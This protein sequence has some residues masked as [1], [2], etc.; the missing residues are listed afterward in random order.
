MCNCSRPIS[1][2]DCQ[3]LLDCVLDPNKGFFIYHI[4]S[5][6]KQNRLEIASVPANKN[7]NTVA[8][9]RGFI[10]KN[11]NPEWYNVN[12]HPCIYKKNE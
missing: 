12:E 6:K 11:G 4:F 5:E 3:R 8:I 1:Q 10:D 7:P 9:E 2:T